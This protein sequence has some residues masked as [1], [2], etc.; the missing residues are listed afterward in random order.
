MNKFVRAVE[1][2]ELSCARA[3]CSA[4]WSPGS[5][6]ACWRC[7]H[8]RAFLMRAQP[9]VYNVWVC[10]NC[11]CHAGPGQ[12][13][14]NPGWP[15]QTLPCL[16]RPG[17]ARPGQAWPSIVSYAPGS[18]GL[19]WARGGR[20]LVDTHWALVGRALVGPTGPLLAGPLWPPLGSCGP[21]PCRP[22]WASVGRSLVG[23]PGPRM[24]HSAKSLG[25]SPSRISF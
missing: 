15:G 11:A 23:H 12:S 6:A 20:P 25:K 7:M 21:G 9:A 13:W 14:S 8:L 4:A 3:L 1:S 19:P 16:A 18:C 22:L 2:M 5:G 10:L 24:Q 17:L